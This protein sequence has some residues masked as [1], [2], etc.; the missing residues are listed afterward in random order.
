M[1][2]R[3]FIGLL[4]VL[5]IGSSLLAKAQI[6][7]DPTIGS[8]T[9]TQNFNTLPSTGNPTWT[10]NTTLSG[11]YGTPAST[12]TFSGMI[13]AT[14][15]ANG[16]FLGSFG[17]SASSDRAL[18]ANPGGANKAWGLRL[19]N[20]G[21]TT[22]TINT[23]S[24]TGEE[25]RTGSGSAQTVSFAYLL[26]ASPITSLS[27]SGYVSLSGLDFTSP[28]TSPTGTNLDGNNAAN[29]VA[30]SLG[31]LAITLAPGTEMML[32]WT[33]LDGAGNDANLAIDN[34]SLGYTTA[35]PEPSTW[36]M[37]FVGLCGLLYF[38]QRRGVR[39]D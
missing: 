11:W 4:S 34:F 7:L 39:H 29:Q 12:G 16:N 17:S 35:V 26:L 3:K 2:P 23:I 27:G 37:I 5:V 19:Q 30:V 9:Y 36:G 22:I 28:V 38:R 13:V 21:T 32:R 33:Y 14:T 20:S 31:S 1:K 8:H 6:V 25:W 10:D 15:G 24:F 18:G